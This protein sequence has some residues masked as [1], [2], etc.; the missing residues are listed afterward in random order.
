MTAFRGLSAGN[1]AIDRREGALKEPIVDY[2]ALTIFSAHNPLA[3][4][5][6]TKS[7]VRRNCQV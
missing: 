2:V 6:V 1:R 4:L 3:T 7:V 5:H